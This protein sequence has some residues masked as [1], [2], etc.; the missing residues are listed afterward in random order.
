MA[1]GS[2]LDKDPTCLPK[3]IQAL[4]DTVPNYTFP[5]GKAIKEYEELASIQG[6]PPRWR[7]SSHVLVAMR[8]RG[9]SLS[10]PA[11][12]R[13]YMKQQCGISYLCAQMSNL[14]SHIRRDARQMIHKQTLNIRRCLVSK[15]TGKLEDAHAKRCGMFREE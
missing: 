4:P 6:H 5:T 9:E 14:L 1:L 15:A 8:G 7:V 13:I 10:R 3:E 2:G 11:Y 12:L